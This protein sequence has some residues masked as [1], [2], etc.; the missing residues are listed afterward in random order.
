[1][2]MPPPRWNYPS[3]P[4]EDLKHQTQKCSLPNDDIIRIFS[5][6]RVRFFLDRCWGGTPLFPCLPFF[7]DL[8]AR[9]GAVGIHL[10][11]G[12]R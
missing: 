12:K 10:S 5:V 1:M 11:Q 2:T 9:E 6:F 7:R 3:K 8:L 4:T